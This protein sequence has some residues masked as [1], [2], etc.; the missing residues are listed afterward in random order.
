MLWHYL[1]AVHVLCCKG[2]MKLTNQLYSLTWEANVAYT[3]GSIICCTKTNLCTPP[4]V[5]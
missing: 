4:H 5:Q 2:L 1:K 3:V